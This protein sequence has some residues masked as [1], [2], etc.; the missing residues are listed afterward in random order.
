MALTAPPPAPTR[1]SGVVRAA[2]GAIT[3]SVGKKT[4]EGQVVDGKARLVV[5]DVRPGA[6]P[7]VVHY[8]GTD[9]VEPAVSRSTVTVPARTKS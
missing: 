1:D 3:V 2:A 4:I 9:L 5:R 8:A 7:V 6:R